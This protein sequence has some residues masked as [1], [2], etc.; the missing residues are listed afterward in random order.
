MKLLDCDSCHDFACAPVAQD[1][2][3]SSLESL[4]IEMNAAPASQAFCPTLPGPAP[5]LLDC[6][7]CHDFAC[8]PVAQDAKKE[9]A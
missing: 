6:D 5:S 8:A 4:T 3:R 1:A 2:K 9:F 7:S